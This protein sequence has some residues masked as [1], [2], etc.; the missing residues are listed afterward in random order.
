MDVLNQPLTDRL[1]AA[2]FIAIWTGWLSVFTM[3]AW[4]QEDWA[5]SPYRVS[6]R[7]ALE[8]LPELTDGWRER[9]GN[10]LVQ[11]VSANFGAAWNVGIE[12]IPPA[13]VPPLLEHEELAAELLDFDDEETRRLDKLMVLAVVAHGAGYRCR[14]REFDVGTRLWG[15]PQT[16]WVRDP[17]RIGDGLLD[18]V[19]QAFRPVGRFVRV[20]KNLVDLSIRASLL[21]DLSSVDIVPRP[22]AVM[23]AVLRRTDQ[24]ARS[25]LT[26][27]SACL[28]RRCGWRR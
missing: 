9:F 28:G 2:T 15:P 13:D 19:I 25:R 8:P 21:S 17:A 4:A 27:F 16:V 24:S 5:A 6:V 18:A 14:V 12:L 20:R 10:R 26:E 22:G 1:R 23:E 7:V 3:V 11:V